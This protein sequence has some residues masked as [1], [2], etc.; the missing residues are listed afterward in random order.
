MTRK[1][2]AEHMMEK[3]ANFYYGVMWNKLY[4]RDILNAY[5]LRGIE[6]VRGFSVQSSVSLLCVERICAAVSDLLL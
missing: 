6:L 5:K 3:P 1:G 2:F 4:R